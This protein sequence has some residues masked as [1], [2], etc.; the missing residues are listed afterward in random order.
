MRVFSVSFGWTFTRFTAKNIK[1]WK[2][3]S[4]TSSPS[5]SSFH[6]LRN[7]IHFLSV[8]RNIHTYTSKCYMSYCLTLPYSSER[9]LGQKD[10]PPYSLS[11]RTMFPCAHSSQFE[12]PHRAWHLAVSRALPCF[13]LRHRRLQGAA[14]DRLTLTPVAGPVLCAPGWDCRATACLLIIFTTILKYSSPHPYLKKG[15]R[16][17]RRQE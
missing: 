4:C 7:V 9:F 10:G 14:C 5:Y 15:T 1:G 6:I 12:Q 2:S 11:P 13:L 3:L 16:M 8:F 17:P